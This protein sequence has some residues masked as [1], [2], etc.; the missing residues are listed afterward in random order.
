MNRSQYVLSRALQ[1]DDLVTTAKGIAS[2]R[3]PS[4]RAKLIE[5][6]DIRG[7]I[8]QSPLSALQCPGLDKYVRESNIQFC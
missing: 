2:P 4:R 8:T 3:R 7:A 6:S 1:T 5:Q